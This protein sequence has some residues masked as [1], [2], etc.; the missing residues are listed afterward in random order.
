MGRARDPNAN[1][2]RDGPGATL[3]IT[4]PERPSS[5]EV[6]AVVTP[7][8]LQGSRQA[9]GAT[10]QI[11]Q[12]I[13]FAVALHELDAFQRFEGADQDCRSNSLGLAHHIQHEM[14]AVVKENVDMARCEIHRADAWR[15]TA[16]MMPGRIA[17]RI[18]FGFNDAAAKASR[19]QFVDDDFPDKETRQGHSVN[20]QFR[21]P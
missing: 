6:E 11:Q 5:A 16:V 4:E 14:R 3:G 19:R 9:P 1:G 13:S 10:R 2:S 17:R 12:A 20:R 21:A 18:S 8:D 15:R 7:I